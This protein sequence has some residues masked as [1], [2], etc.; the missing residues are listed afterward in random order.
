[1]TLGG[2]AVGTSR[3]VAKGSR[4]AEYPTDASRD[5]DHVAALADRIETFLAGV[6]ATRAIGEQHAD[7]DTVD[8]LT[9]VIS[10]FEKNAWFLRATLA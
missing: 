3:A 8:L 6:R 2:A 9:A 10:D 7:L 5:L 4:L 1:V